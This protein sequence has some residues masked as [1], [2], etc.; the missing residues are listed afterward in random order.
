[1]WTFIHSFI[2]GMHHYECEAPNVDTA[3]SERLRLQCFTWIWRYINFITYWLTNLQSGQLWAMS[4]AS[5]RESFIDFRFCWVVFIHVVRARPG[6]LLQFSKG[7]AV[8]ICLASDSSDVR[9]V[10]PNRE[11][12]CLNSSRKMWLLC[13]PSDVIITHMVVPFIPSSLCRHHW[14][15]AHTQEFL[16]HWVSSS[17]LCKQECFNWCLKLSIESSGSCRY[18]GI[19]IAAIAYVKWNELLLNSFTFIWLS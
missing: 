1:M 10:W 12:P 17:V 8:K 5:F 15:R 14:T 13:F 16:V 3:V 9:T 6:G 11:A 7:E 2:S 4:V 19:H 18:S